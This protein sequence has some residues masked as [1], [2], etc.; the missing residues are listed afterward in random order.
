MN[1]R[2]L[3]AISQAMPNVLF[4]AII[5]YLSHLGLPELVVK[6]STL[7]M[8]VSF[9]QPIVALRFEQQIYRIDVR[10]VADI[11][12]TVLFCSLITLVVAFFV[13]DRSWFSQFS[14]YEVHLSIFVSWLFGVSSILRQIHYRAD[15]GKN[16]SLINIVSMLFVLVC[17]LKIGS[18]TMYSFL[19]PSVLV[20]SVFLVV[21]VYFIPSAYKVSSFAGVVGVFKQ[22]WI[23][24]SK[25]CVSLVAAVAAANA[26]VF[27]FTNHP[28]Q[29]YASK[30]LVL[31]RLLLLPVSLLAIPVSQLIAKDLA[32]AGERVKTLRRYM[33]FVFI[34]LFLYNLFLLF[35]LSCSKPAN[36]YLLSLD[37][38]I[39]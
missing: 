8:M 26:L 20:I 5:I 39:A 9:I 16:I 31:I 1:N 27:V 18:A 33:V 6:Y 17:W 25:L 29:V 32:C 24:A 19:L 11:Y 7:F 22:G 28:D 13:I 36:K 30:M 35:S 10:N 4:G 3:Y 38:A 23:D 2:V 37:K 15:G 12:S 34:S 21:Q 14:R